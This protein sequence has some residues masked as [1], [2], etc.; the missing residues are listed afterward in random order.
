[1]V[2]ITTTLPNEL[3]YIVKENKYMTIEQVMDYVD[4]YGQFQK[5]NEDGQSNS[6]MPSAFAF[7]LIHILN[8]RTILQKYQFGPNEEVGKM[9]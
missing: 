6:N 8:S 1:M 5:P 2:E 3:L 9:G 7:P 4:E